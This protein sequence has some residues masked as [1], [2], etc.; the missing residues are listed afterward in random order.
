MT[1]RKLVADEEEK[2]NAGEILEKFL[3]NVNDDAEIGT[4]LQEYL[5]ERNP[6]VEKIIAADNDSHE[7][8]YRHIPRLLVD[9]Y[10]SEI[11]EAKMGGKLRDKILQKL[12]EKNEFQII[13]DIYVV[14]KKIKSDEVL[15][16][17]K[18]FNNDR[19]TE[20]QKYLKHLQDHKA[21]PWSPG[22]KY[23]NTFVDKLRLARIFAGIKSDSKRERM[24]SVP[25]KTEIKELKDFQK[26]MK[27]QV[28]EILEGSGEKRAIITLPTGG[29]KTRVAVEAIVEFLNK[30]GVQ[31]NILWIAQSDE[32]CEQAVLCFKQIWEAYGKG[33]NLEIFRAWDTHDLPTS[34]ETGIIVAGYQK[35]LSKKN[36]LHN[37]CDNE[38]LS[39]VFIDE[40]H[41]SIAKSYTEILK[42][43]ELS[44]FKGGILRNDEL[45]PLI[46][47]T[48]TPERRIDSETRNLLE[49]YG[50]KRIYPN[51]NFLPDSEEGDK[52]DENWKDLGKMKKKLTDLKYLAKAELIGID[53]GNKVIKLSQ[54]ETE[55]LESGGDKWMKRLATESERNI[56]I[57]NEILKW[58]DKGRKILYFGTNVSQSISMARIL[59]KRGIRSASITGDTRFA[60]RKMIINIFNKRDSNEIQ[61]MCNY[62]VLATG[63]DSPEIDTV[64]IARP[65]TSIVAY[66][67][68][69]GRGLRG[70]KFGGK[71]GNKCEIVTVKD[72][73]QKFNN[74]EVELGHSIYQ[75]EVEDAENGMVE[76]D[77]VF[78]NDDI[79]SYGQITNNLDNM[80][81]KYGDSFSNDEIY[82]KYRVQKQGGI[83]Y[84]T[85]HNYIILI[86]AENSNYQDHVDEKSGTIIYNGT[87]EMDQG[88]EVGHEQF[89]AKVKDP[90]S[91]LLY[92]QRPSGANNIFK[93]EVK[94]ISH[95][96][97]YEKNKIGTY[98]KVIKF[99][100][101]IIR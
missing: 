47:L 40:A 16:H 50:E 55:D 44:S 69:I 98:R 78:D 70:E 97:S 91:I 1:D 43:L 33:E 85:K 57:K 54:L 3:F 34:E 72:N 95:S 2:K 76:R 90:N 49:M 52:F 27:N 29:G 60:T 35:L 30:S 63:F 77:Q 17:K 99:N 31:K 56:N 101:K 15:N 68:M 88:F 53:P 58:A 84:T 23:A 45:V 19:E 11:F 42:H 48:A 65:T 100:L 26:N 61:V 92:F 25:T 94:Y 32:I 12:L 14:S 86:D 37:L 66:Q 7:I 81:P 4:W 28:V 38:R 5:E 96:F 73:I 62:N 36:E 59:E 13:F 74:D 39:A 67:Q 71:V 64:I 82:E 83:R 75:K 93:Y 8:Q 79:E 20:C 18:I 87:G 80:I 22:G 46:G 10:G 51:P 89:N 9:L 41:H 21:S 6:G 24:I